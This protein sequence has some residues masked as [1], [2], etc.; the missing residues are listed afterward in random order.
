MATDSGVRGASDRRLGDPP[1]CPLLHV[2]IM[3]SE[4]RLMPGLRDE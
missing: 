1:W 2:I 4:K 3:D